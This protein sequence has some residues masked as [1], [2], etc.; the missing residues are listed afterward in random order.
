LVLLFS[1]HTKTQ[2]HDAG[3][4]TPRTHRLFCR[5]RRL[6]GATIACFP[7]PSLGTLSPRTLILASSP[8]ANIVRQPPAPSA[9][10]CTRGAVRGANGLSVV[11]KRRVAGRPPPHNTAR[12]GLREI[13]KGMIITVTFAGPTL[14]VRDK[15][16]E[17]RNCSPACLLCPDT[18]PHLADEGDAVM[19]GSLGLRASYAVKWSKKRCGCHDARHHPCCY[20]VLRRPVSGRQS[21]TMRALRMHRPVGLLACARTVSRMG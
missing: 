6:V 2:L 19:H 11:A 8:L 4:F 1:S 16:Q 10:A 17:T 15:R 9:A 7:C 18:R 14:G 13:W 20:A 21:K 3:L 5:R 12:R